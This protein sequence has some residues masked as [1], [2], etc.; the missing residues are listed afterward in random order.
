M[1][2]FTVVQSRSQEE[3]EVVSFGPPLIMGANTSRDYWNGPNNIMRIK[4]ILFH[5]ICNII[6]CV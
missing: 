3:E 4:E 1:D 6:F 5:D 2:I